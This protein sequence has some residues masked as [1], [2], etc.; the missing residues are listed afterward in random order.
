MKNIRKIT[1]ENKEIY[2][3]PTAHVSKVSAEEVK[4]T[5]ETIKPD[6]V[7][8]ELDN[9]RY[10][11]IINPKKFEEMDIF[12]VIKENKAGYLM[13]NLILS[14][15]QKR[16]AS[17]LDIKAGA[18]MIQAIESA[19]K[20]NSKI[21]LCDR[22]IQTTFT[23]IYRKHSFLQKINIISSLIT[24][25]FDKSEIS[26]DEIENLKNSDIL[27]NALTS[28]YKE[29]PIIAK[30]LIDERD[31]YIAHNI[32]NAEGNIIVAVLGA[33]HVEGVISE[34]NK[35]Q[36]IFELDKLPKKS[37]VG[38]IIGSILGIALI[39]MILFTL[40]TNKVGAENQIISW[41]LWNGGLSAL[42]VI[43]ALG[44]P[45]SVLTAFIM[46]PITSLS[47]FLAAGWFAGLCEA[48]IKK[49]KVK[50]FQNIS[51]DISSIKGIYKNRITHILLVVI[52]ANLFS[53]IGT[54]IGGFDVV[55]IFLN[56][57][58]P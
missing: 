19:N 3:I 44:N 18:E 22:K 1:L 26:E 58:L 49:P 41:I 12:K 51:D 31:Q 48:I 25:I 29:F 56:N 37:N 35:Q 20:I 4:E 8:I 5:I 42:G 30:I 54:F 40:S 34:F 45:I 13:A 24:T 17:K 9:D 11:S 50:D 53:T 47:P 39:S 28:V 15:Y 52:F 36:N 43:F 38:V 55:K 6:C 10:Q 23:R 32:K 27:D 2:I 14:S 57:L 21:V 16:I 46:A 7:C 33:A